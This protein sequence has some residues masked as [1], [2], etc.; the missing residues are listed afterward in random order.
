M[1]ALAVIALGLLLLECKTTLWVGQQVIG[2]D[3][4]AR[5]TVIYTSVYTSHVAGHYGGEVTIL[6]L[7]SG[8]SYSINPESAFDFNGAA[9]AWRRPARC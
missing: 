3:A 5:A 2:N 9:L 4:H 1:K 6:N 8:K 7:V